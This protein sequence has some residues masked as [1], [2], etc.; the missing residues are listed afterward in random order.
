MIHDTPPFPRASSAKRGKFI[1]CLYVGGISPA[2]A[3]DQG[4]ALDLQA[5]EKA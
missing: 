2:V 3:G 5:F 4:A 1:G